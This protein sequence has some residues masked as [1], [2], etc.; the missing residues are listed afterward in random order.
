MRNAIL[1]LTLAL[2]TLSACDPAADRQPDLFLAG[3]PGS[4]DE[5]TPRGLDDPE[6]WYV[7]Q[8]EG[9]TIDTWVAAKH[10]LTCVGVA[11][12]TWSCTVS[13]YKPD[14]TKPNFVGGLGCSAWFTPDLK[15]CLLKAYQINGA[16]K[17]Q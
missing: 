9:N 5:V 6:A 12:P 4:P 8:W 17:I 16:I 10:F 1:T 11:N 7:T 13:W 2:L 14:T 15:G 3:P